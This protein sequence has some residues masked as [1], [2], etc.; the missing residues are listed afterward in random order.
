MKRLIVWVRTTGQEHGVDPETIILAGRSA[1]AHLTAMAALTA[2]DP[3]FQPGFET[4][5]ASIAAG[6]GLGG[7]YGPIGRAGDP[8]STPMT[9]VRADA[10]PFLIVHGG[11]DTY[12]PPAGARLLADRLRAASSQAVV[13]AELPGA[14]HS[15][16]LFHSMRFE[17]VV[18]GI[19]AFAAWVRTRA[20][21]RRPATRTGG[22]VT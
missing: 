11:Q 9:Y 17:P 22:A 20:D 10:P 18:D 8:P 21:D 15:Y 16:D 12:T 13:Y 19:E 5:D 1:G 14:Q 6:I 7:Y 4:S 3:T 2:N